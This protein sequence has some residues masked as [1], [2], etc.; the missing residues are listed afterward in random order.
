MKFVI[1]HLHDGGICLYEKSDVDLIDLGDIHLKKLNEKHESY[2][3]QHEWIFDYHYIKKVLCGKVTIA[4]GTKERFTPK[5][6]LV[7]QME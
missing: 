1:K 3:Y 5:R 6:I 4:F 2:C 7:I